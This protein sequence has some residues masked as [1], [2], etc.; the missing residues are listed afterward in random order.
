LYSFLVTLPEA[1]DNSSL[2][3]KNSSIV[4]S[5]GVSAKRENRTNDI[6]FASEVETRDAKNRE[7]VSGFIPLVMQ[8][9]SYKGLSV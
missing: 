5:N 8:Y 2:L 4:P 9:F 1:S 6:E 3:F 7:L